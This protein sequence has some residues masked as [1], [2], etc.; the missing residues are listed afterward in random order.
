MHTQIQHLI[1]GSGAMWFA[2][3]STFDSVQVAGANKV[4]TT[5]RPATTGGPAGGIS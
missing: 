2:Y 4:R 1:A 5:I 3:A